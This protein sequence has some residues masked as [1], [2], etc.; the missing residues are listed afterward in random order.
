VTSDLS[1]PIPNPA[2]IFLVNGHR[3][4]RHFAGSR[5]STVSNIIALL[6]ESGLCGCDINPRLIE[7]CVSNISFAQAFTSEYLPPL[8]GV[9]DAQFDFVYAASVFT[10]LTLAAAKAWAGEFSRTIAPDGI[11]MASFDPGANAR[12]NPFASYQDIAILRRLS[13]R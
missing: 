6:A 1:T 11:L 13:G 10:H 4:Q 7:F 9:T 12:P 8:R 3:N 2:L 5:R